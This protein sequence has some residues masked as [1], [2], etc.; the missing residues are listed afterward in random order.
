MRESEG[1][2]WEPGGD[3]SDKG[4]DDCVGVV[5]EGDELSEVLKC[6]TFLSESICKDQ[7]SMV[8]NEGLGTYACFGNKIKSRERK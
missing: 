6:R 2:G 3:G 4:E 5:E 1:E 7:T 8:V